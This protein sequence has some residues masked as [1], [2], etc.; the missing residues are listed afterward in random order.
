MNGKPP[1]MTLESNGVQRSLTDESLASADDSPASRP[2]SPGGRFNL[3]GGWKGNGQKVNGESPTTTFSDRSASPGQS[4][5]LQTPTG[6]DPNMTS[7]TRLTPPG[8]D[9][10]KANTGTPRREYFENPETPI[11]IGTPETN[12]HVREL[13]RELEHVSAELASSVKREMELEDELDRM[14]IEG[15]GLLQSDAGRRTS[16]Y[17]SDS[18]ASSTRYPVTDVDGKL[19]QMER[20]LRKAEQEKAQ[21][22]VEMASRLQTELSRRRDLEQMVQKMEE[23]LQKKFEEDDEK[24]DAEDRIDE[25]ESTLEDT[26]RLLSQERQAKGSFE[27]LYTATKEELEQHRN[28]RDNLRDEVVPGLKARV[29]GLEADASDTQALMYENTRMQQ[30]LM[31][32]KQGRFGSIAEEGFDTTSPSLGGPRT[33]LSRSG[34]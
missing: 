18:G 16:D 17:F 15:P 1:E 21:I 4:P 34:S 3:F 2:K 23:Q 7:T 31:A 27:D 14:K 25:L 13:E 6:I 28:E 26:R 33:G 30:E 8:L 9:I 22:K 10:Q 24:G 32:L 20:S 19:E 29:E 11:L 12:A 5:H